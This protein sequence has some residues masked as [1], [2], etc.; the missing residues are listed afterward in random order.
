[1]INGVTELLMMKADVLSGFETVKVCTQYKLKNDTV[2][3]TVPFDLLNEIKS[4]VYKSFA[5]WS[6]HTE[7]NTLTGQKGYD[8][9]PVQIKEYIS[10]L[11][12]N[13]RLPINFVSLGPDRKQT[14]MKYEKSNS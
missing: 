12:E 8:A 14:L 7:A 3:D 2:I 6:F 5:G 4:P 10:F 1:M 11:E 9:L 13:L